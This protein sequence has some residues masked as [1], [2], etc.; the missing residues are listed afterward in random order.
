MEKYSALFQ[1]GKI[2]TLQLDNRLIMSAMGVSLVDGRGHPIPGTSTYYRV[3]AEGGIGLII[4]QCVGVSED[5]AT[6]YEL[7]LYDDKFIPGLVDV[8]NAV[9]E[10]GGKICIQLMH[11]GMLITF[12]GFLQPELKIKVPSMT[13][14]MTGDRPFEVVT[15]EDI[16]RY[17]ED[18]SD[19]ARRVK[20]TGADAVELH[21]CHGCLL[22]SFMT[23]A[24]NHRTDKYGGSI[25][26]RMRFTRRVV[27]RTKEKTGKDFPLIVKMD[28]DNDVEGGVTIDE[29]LQQ[30]AILE[31]AGAD[32]I[33]V[34][35]GI[36]YWSSLSIPCFAY[37]EAPIVPLA[38][39]IKQAVRVPVLTAGKI[40]PELA[41]QLIGD[42][43]LDF[44]GMARPILADP[45]LPNKLR[46]GRSED[47]CPCVYC[48]NCIR[49]DPAPMCSVNPF[50]WRENE[51]LLPP[52]DSPKKVMVI[53]GGL[54]GMQASIFLKQRGHD[55]SLYERKN[56][57]GGQ[58]NVASAMTGKGHFAKFTEYLKRQLGKLEIPI[59]LGI[60]ITKDQV[61]KMQPDAVVVATGAVPLTLDVPG[62]TSRHVVQANDVI[63][64]NAEAKANVVVVGG[65]FIGMETAIMLAEQGKE[66]TIVT[67][68]MLG[69]NGSRLER[70]VYRTLAK[71]LIELRVPL[72]VNAAVLEITKR[73]VVIE[74]GGELFP[75][76]AD[77]VVLAVGARSENKLA[78]DLKGEVKELYVIG[79][80]DK[81]RDASA[82]SQEALKVAARI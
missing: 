49:T 73:S 19:A 56:E 58:W 26:N 79:D 64:G 82:A 71:R 61:L 77:T 67:Q 10:V 72:F 15:E 12:A 39:K 65:R 7:S 1:P 23:P 55:V 62:A 4:T 38:E 51:P 70:M 24:M 9:H 42:G 29:V 17:V 35:S 16:D 75:I 32:A 18:F 36:E 25:E 45:Q 66:V 63:I 43:R 46:E 53:G 81:P 21:A 27:E 59:N 31:K 20:D 41:E 47:I 33:N 8:V 78:T 69:E 13:S 5:Q 50:L 3:R 11:F 76:Q 74:W 57:L 44:I 2:G 14:W 54:A 48:N 6:F 60:D 30:A 40:S 68:A 28:C 34:S 80:C 52:T 37:P 22:G